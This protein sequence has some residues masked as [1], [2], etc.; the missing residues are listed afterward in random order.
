MNENRH[1]SNIK[2]FSLILLLVQLLHEKLLF[3]FL[4]SL[5]FPLSLFIKQ[6]ESEVNMMC[7]R[8]RERASESKKEK[9]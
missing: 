5:S 6:R 9:R 7:E 1:T 2:T 4:L 8:R 3:R